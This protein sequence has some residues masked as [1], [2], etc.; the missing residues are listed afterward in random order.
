MTGMYTNARD[1]LTKWFERR[2]DIEAFA[3]LTDEAL[4]DLMLSD[5]VVLVLD[6]SNTELHQRIKRS[7]WEAL[8]VS[9]RNVLVWSALDGIV[10][11]VVKE[12]RKS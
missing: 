9:E 12:L 7:I 11:A 10:T 4:A 6:P 8:P 1:D 3:R 5:G 2:L